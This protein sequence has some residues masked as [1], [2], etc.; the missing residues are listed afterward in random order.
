MNS[1]FPMTSIDVMYPA[2]VMMFVLLLGMTYSL[3]KPSHASTELDKQLLTS[4]ANVEGW[5][6]LPPWQKRASQKAIEKYSSA[7]E[8]KWRRWNEAMFERSE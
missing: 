3:T 4:V 6:G 2:R 1:T 5:G 7:Q 8:K